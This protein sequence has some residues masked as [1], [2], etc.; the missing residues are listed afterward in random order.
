MEKIKIEIR[1][2]VIRENGFGQKKFGASVS[3]E[4]SIWDSDRGNLSNQ[5]RRSFFCCKMLAK[6]SSIENNDEIDD[7]FAT[8]GAHFVDHITQI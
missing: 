6:P 4:L 2:L 3:R 7:E 8:R 1:E 5:L